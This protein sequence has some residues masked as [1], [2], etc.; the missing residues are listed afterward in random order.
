MIQGL[1]I[2]TASLVINK[3]SKEE[4]RRF[5]RKVERNIKKGWNMIKLQPWAMN[6]MTSVM[7]FLCG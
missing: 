6:K 5:E 1:S 2:L 4:N 7:T 3:D